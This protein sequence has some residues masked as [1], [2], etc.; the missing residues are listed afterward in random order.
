MPHVEIVDTSCIFTIQNLIAMGDF[1]STLQVDESWGHRAWADLMA[2]YIGE[3]LDR[4]N[5]VDIRPNPIIPTWTNRRFGGEFIGKRIDR[6]MVK[7]HM[8]AWMGNMHTYTHVSDILDHMAAVLTWR[9]ESRQKGV[10][11][12]FNRAWLQDEEYNVIIQKQ[13]E[14]ISSFSKLAGWAHFQE[15]L[16]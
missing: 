15:K 10:P 6:A 11:F 9:V 12:K 5:M 3:I 7:E 1:N 8:V 4:T 2:V 14:D 16:Q 13:C